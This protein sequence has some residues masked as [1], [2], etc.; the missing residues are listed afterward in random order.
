MGYNNY[1]GYGGWG[2]GGGQSGGGAEPGIPGEE[3]GPP[4]EENGAAA[5]SQNQ[6]Q[7]VAQA[8]MAAA[9]YNQNFPAMGGG[10]NQWG[11]RPGMPQFGGFNPVPTQVK[12]KKKKKAAEGGPGAAG[13]PG[14]A[15]PAGVTPAA[16]EASPLPGAAEWP[17]SLK[18]YV[19][20]CFSQC[21]TDVDKDMVE[22]LLKGKITAAAGSNSLWTKN[23]DEEPLPASLSKNTQPLGGGR[24]VQGDL[25]SQ[26]KVVRAGGFGANNFG[27]NKNLDS[28][29]RKKRRSSS[30]D[31]PDYGGNANM[32][33][34]GGAKVM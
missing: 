32:V 25:G 34:L 29:K 3:E 11:V 7:A 31:G 1:Q 12:K 26:G 5:A 27:Q 13:L 22:I 15:G 2:P 16:K 9:S 4:G 8:Q 10:Y 6:N 18:N 21:V 24:A 33:P 14:A 28:P 23:W 30:G 20:K 19:S 17:P